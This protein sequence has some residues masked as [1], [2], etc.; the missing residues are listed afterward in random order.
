MEISFLSKKDL[1]QVWY[2]VFQGIVIA[3][4]LR[5]WAKEISANWVCDRV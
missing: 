5:D 1:R 4:I 3:P 2:Y